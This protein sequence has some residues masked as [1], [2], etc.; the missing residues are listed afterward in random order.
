M[1]MNNPNL[2]SSSRRRKRRWGDA[3][4][5][6]KD[7]ENTDKQ[8]VTATS[9]STPTSTLTTGSKSALAKAEALQE[10]VRARLAALRASRGVAAVVPKSKNITTTNNSKKANTNITTTTTTTTTT[11]NLPP[12]SNE[13]NNNNNSELVNHKKARIYDLDLSMTAPTRIFPNNNSSSIIGGGGDYKNEKE[14]KKMKELEQINNNPYLAHLHHKNDDVNTAATDTADTATN[15]AHTG[16]AKDNLSKNNNSNNAVS[17]ATS[18]S[19]EEPMILDDVRLAGGRMQRI[20]RLSYKAKKK[21]ASYMLEDPGIIPGT[22]V[23]IAD[24]ARLRMD[25]AEQSGF[26]SGR[27]VGT[28][29]KGG[30]LYHGPA[31]TNAAGA[32]TNILLDMDNNDSQ[33]TMMIGGVGGRMPP[34]SDAPEESTDGSTIGNLGVVAIPAPLTVEWWDVDLLPNRLRKEVGNLEAKALKERMGNLKKASSSSTTSSS[35]IVTDDVDSGTKSD[36]GK[37]G[38]DNKENDTTTTTTTITKR[39]KTTSTK[40]KNHKKGIDPI[41][42]AAKILRRKCR[43]TSSLTNSK[44]SRLIQHPAPIVRQSNTIQ[45]SSSTS[46]T[47][48]PTQQQ[49]KTPTIHLTKAER[50]RRRK[51][52]RIER[53]SEQRDKQAAGLLPPPEPRLTLANFVKVL[54]DQ[55]ILDPSGAEQLAKRQI[56]K[57]K[58]K[59]DDSNDSRKLSKLEKSKKKMDKLKED[60][61]QGVCVALFVIHDLSHVYHRTKVDLNAR[62][63]NITGGVLECTIGSNGGSA[64]SGSEGST[65]GSE[66]NQNK[67]TL[68]VCEGGPKS[69]KRYTRLMLVRMKWDGDGMDDDDDDDDDDDGQD[70]N[71]NTMEQTNEDDLLMNNNHNEMM[72]IDNNGNYDGDDN[73][74]DESQT[75]TKRQKFNKHNKCELIWTGMAP[76]RSFPNFAFQN[77]DNVLEARKVLEAR[78]AAHFWDR[79]LVH[80]Q[81]KMG[82][83]KYGGG[84]GGY[85]G[86]GGLLGMGNNNDDDDDDGVGFGEVLDDVNDQDTIHDY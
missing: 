64:G 47:S 9:T 42:N 13:N 25:N 29:V 32:S 59:H 18:T 54:G 7:D 84:G 30:G 6:N 68:V 34:R 14:R 53:Q 10:S 48:T 11:T 46:T 81:R 75:K 40:H 21:T 2:S 43:I 8:V 3:T 50:K 71:M 74:N 85:G 33:N 45:S 41:R 60:E 4:T 56:L 77:C 37:K 23:K 73:N 35:T 57:R 63:N 39:N 19:I 65:T 31:A 70:G 66:D 61:S 58:Q 24:Q 80:F 38:N 86:G 28:Y 12:P 15:D 44:T 22:F 27:K 83:G 67:M 55:A 17:S 82:G 79:A 78:G 26:V 16:N 72:N 69:I 1:T 76:R 20:S 49:Q 5:T 52:R 62:Q 36:N 51:L